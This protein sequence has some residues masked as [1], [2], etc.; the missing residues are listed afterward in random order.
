MHQLSDYRSQEHGAVGCLC[1]FSLIRAK[2]KSKL[3]VTKQGI[4]I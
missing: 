3:V 2:K 4:S 1:K